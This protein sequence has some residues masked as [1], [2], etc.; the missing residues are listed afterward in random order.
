[1]LQG[2]NLGSKIKNPPTEVTDVIISTINII[3][4]LSRMQV[5]TTKKIQHIVL[6]EA[7]TLLDDSFSKDV[8]NFLDPF[9]VILFLVKVKHEPLVANTYVK[10]TLQTL[11]FWLQSAAS[12]SPQLYF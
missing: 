1:M 8:A 2:G 12:A 7:D 3:S 6:D 9:P 5:Y 10:L 11:C 4:T